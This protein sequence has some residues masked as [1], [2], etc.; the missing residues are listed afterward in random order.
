MTMPQY[1]NCAHSDT[2]WCLDCVKKEYEDSV[3]EL[4]KIEQHVE[5]LQEK[6]KHVVN[7]L[8]S[9]VSPPEAKM[10]KHCHIIEEMSLGHFQYRRS[11]DEKYAKRI[12]EVESALVAAYQKCDMEVHCV[13]TPI[14]DKESV[15]LCWQL[16]VVN[17][18][19]DNVEIALIANTPVRAFEDALIHVSHRQNKV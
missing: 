9:H 14:F 16:D 13:I 1:M 11:H 17:N 3:A 6:N 12:R 5:E 4:Q 7:Q 18:A 19:S 8:L 10:Q 15:S 2:G